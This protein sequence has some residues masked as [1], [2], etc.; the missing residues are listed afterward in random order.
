[1]QRTD[2]VITETAR[3]MGIR[4]TFGQKAGGRNEQETEK[5]AVQETI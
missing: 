5:E 1:M 2:T 3:H 4:Q